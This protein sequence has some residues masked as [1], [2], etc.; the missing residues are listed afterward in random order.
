MPSSF[1]IFLLSLTTLISVAITFYLYRWRKIFLAEPHTYVPEE[2]GKMIRALTD[3]IKHNSI[4]VGSNYKNL[5]QQL[6][7]SSKDFSFK[8]SDTNQKVKELAEMFLTLNKNL[9]EKEDE[10]RRLKQGYDKKLNKKFIKRFA[11]VDQAASEMIEDG[12]INK[13]SFE[14]IKELLEDALDECDTN[15]FS[16]NIG[17]D[18][19]QTEGV[20]DNP[21]IIPSDNK[22]DE[23]KISEIIQVG[24]Y[25]ETPNGP[26]VIIPCKVKIFDEYKNN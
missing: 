6:L 4:I 15:S 10:I 23:F 3:G 2:T 22:E 17:D 8:S 5:K 16:P 7:Q 9:T 24:Y 20:A 1:V 14:E 25:M 11:L 21:K 19:R 26:E 18:Y 13:E 12:E